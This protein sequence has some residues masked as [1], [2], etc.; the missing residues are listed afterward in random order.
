MKALPQPDGSLRIHSW[1]KK[2][3]LSNHVEALSHFA[4][5]SLSFG[6]FFW[7][8]R[9]QRIEKPVLA[10]AGAARGGGGRGGAALG[11]ELLA[12]AAR[13]QVHRRLVDHVVLDGVDTNLN[14]EQDIMEPLDNVIIT[15][16]KIQSVAVAW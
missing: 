7:F 1:Q 16:E 8:L 4:P 3:L 11:L 13:R 10:P 9:G 5:P 6:T 14:K 15:E 2:Y 12:A